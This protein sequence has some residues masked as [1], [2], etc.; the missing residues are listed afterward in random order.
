MKER[1]IPLVDENCGITIPAQN[2]EGEIFLGSALGRVYRIDPRNNSVTRIFDEPAGQELWTSP[3]LDDDANIYIAATD[4]WY[5]LSRSGG[6]RW[7]YLMPAGRQILIGPCA[8]DTARN[9]VFVGTANPGLSK[10]Y[11]TC[12]DRSSGAVLQE[13]QADDPWNSQGFGAASVGTDGTVFV[14]SGTIL[15]ALDGANVNGP[16]KWTRDFFPGFVNKNTPAISRDGS[17]IYISY[18]K[19]IGGPWQMAFAAL[20]AA[21]GATK[22]EQPF[23][24]GDSDNICQ[25]YAASN[26]I[27]VFTLF[28]H[29]LG[30][31]GQFTLFAYRDGGDHPEYLWEK[32]VG[33]SGGSLAFGPGATLYMIP[34]SGYGHTVYA[35]TEGDTGD[36][37]GA[38]M[39]WNNNA[40]PA[41]PSNPTPTS[42]ATDRETSVTLSWSCSDPEGQDLKYDVFLGDATMTMLP[43]A[44]WLT[45]S[46]YTVN[47]LAPGTSYIWKVV[48]TDGQAVSESPTWSFATLAATKDFSLEP[49]YDLVSLPFDGT[50]ISDAEALAQAVPNCAAVWQWD[51]A[52]QSWSGHPKGGPNNFSVEAGGGYLVSVTGVGTFHT[53]GAWAIR[54]F[55]L[56]A[57]YNLVSLLK[58]RDQITTAEQMLQ[59]I[60]N[61]TAVWRWDATAQ[62]WSGH[63]LG[64]PNNFAVTVGDAYLVHVSADGIW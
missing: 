47:G 12:L 14:G 3:K 38:A 9:R 7:T 51:A 46:S 23:S 56:K 26:G 35:I 55:S 58:S 1:E 48:A 33:A 13:R 8:I 16:T 30:G 21:T 20:D 27:V 39:G 54:S 11:L 45:T 4:R 29:G 31:A 61:G 59:S 36:P 18:Y 32:S 25:S 40:A 52:T 17:T 49:V 15:Y 62:G 43:L 50:G 37:D 2:S 60:P 34:T 63:P 24:C 44:R 19:Q 53:S 64:G 5:S 41:A 6:V 57:G 10:T 28:N 42:G 22:W